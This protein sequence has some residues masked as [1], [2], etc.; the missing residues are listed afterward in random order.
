MLSVGVAN[1]NAVCSDI[2]LSTFNPPSGKNC[3]EYLESF[4]SFAGGKLFNPEATSNC[5]VCSI[6][7]TNVF[8]AQVHSVY[9][10]RWRN[11]GIL[12]AFVIFNV[13][14]AFFF[15]WLAR[16]PKGAKSRNV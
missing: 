16:V 3:G 15:Y 8:L 14:A 10:E 12:W 7:D 13:S 1:T 4:L 6:S 9:T 11:F 5:S 2:E